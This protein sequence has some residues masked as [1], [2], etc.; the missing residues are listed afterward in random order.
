MSF[1]GLQPFDLAAKP[2]FAVQGS[3]SSASTFSQEAG[4][5]QASVSCLRSYGLQSGGCRSGPGRFSRLWFVV[6]LKAKTIPDRSWAAGVA[7]VKIGAK[8]MGTDRTEIF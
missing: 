8:F 3:L 6:R 7:A 5:A 4:S 1:V 2:A